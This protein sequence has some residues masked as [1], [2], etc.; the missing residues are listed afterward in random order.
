MERQ[1]SQQAAEAGDD[2]AERLRRHTGAHENATEH[3]ALAEIKDAGQ[4]RKKFWE[5]P[6]KFHCPVIGTCFT[7]DEL[8]HLARKAGIEAGAGDYELHHT[9]VHIA[10]ERGYPARLLQKSLERKFAAT[11]RHAAA[12]ANVKA[13]AD[14][15]QTALAQGDVGAAFWAVLTHPFSDDALMQHVYG[16]VHMR[17]H[18]AGHA[19]RAADRELPRHRQRIATLEAA[20]ARAT[21]ALR[22]RAK[23]GEHTA[24]ELAHQLQRGTRLE[25]DL[26]A[27]RARIAELEGGAL[28]TALRQQNAALNDALARAT[29]RA[30][31]AERERERWSR[32]AATRAPA[33]APTELTAASTPE[34]PPETPP[35]EERCAPNCD[36]L[37]AGDCPGPDLC[38]RRILYVGGRERQLAHFRALVARRNGELLHHD[39]GRHES[40][41][42]LDALIRSADAV[43]CPIECVS[44]DACRRIKRLCKRERKPFVPLRSASLTGFADGLRTIAVEVNGVLNA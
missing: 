34:P 25:R 29:Q 42:H 37:A 6:A 4:R 28:L 33:Q 21:S 36:A 11:I 12:Y 18:L 44:H 43:L 7:L 23:A 3:P 19:A 24:V 39:G 13:L 9:L 1:R 2:R 31:D 15:W 10:G 17:S 22:E 30:L 20:L 35:M 27:A 41:A 40:S 14:F 38:G 5:L 16:E 32:L 8:R 26:A